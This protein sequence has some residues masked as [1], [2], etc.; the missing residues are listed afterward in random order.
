[1]NIRSVL[2]KFVS[3]TVSAVLIATAV[4]SVGKA[5]TDQQTLRG[6]I[7]TD[8][9]VNTV[10][11]SILG[12]YLKGRASI[13]RQGYINAD[14]DGDGVLDSLDLIL[15]RKII[16]HQKQLQSTT[17]SDVTVSG[18]CM[19]TTICGSCD[20]TV[21]TNVEFYSHE[22][23]LDN[24]AT[25]SAE[26]FRPAT[27]TFTSS[28]TADGFVRAPLSDMQGS[29]SSQGEGRVCILYVDFRDCQYKWSPT[30]SSMNEMAFGE[31]DKS[32][33]NYP[34]ES[35]SA[36]FKRSS[37]QTLNLSGRVYRYT[38][39]HKKAYYERDDHKETLVNEL[40]REM[41]QYVDFNSF[42]ANGDKVIDSIIISVPSQ[43]GDD[44]WWS[45]TANYL[46]EYDGL[47][48]GLAPGHV[49]IGNCEIKSQ[50]DYKSFVASYCHELGHCMGLPDYYLYNNHDSEGLHGSAGYDIMD[51]LYSDFSCASKL[52][53]GWYRS[54]QV[55][56]YNGSQ[57]QTFILRNA[58]TDSGNCVIIPRDELAPNYCSES[59]IIEYTTLDNNNSYIPTQYWWRNFGSGVRVFHMEPSGDNN[60]VNR[61]FLYRSGNNEATNYN[62]GKR[63]IRIVND[64]EFDNLL[65]T[66]SIIDHNQYGFGFYGSYDL[67][68]V[69]PGIE[70]RVGE[71]VDDAYTITISRKAQ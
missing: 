61:N 68:N 23:W 3:F 1:M 32:N 8:G 45:F 47:L 49:V 46:N 30:T 44:D 33:A 57:E 26:V 11:L 67:E 21:T 50:D 71:L 28:L 17:T 39:L 38:T 2:S 19:T 58:Q 53:L 5:D 13:D 66:G 65:R 63:F 40:L 41:D 37:K 42:D 69:D 16:L 70:I 12:L 56:V 51:E 31:E 10:D 22:D 7:N 20:T 4:P 15:L 54:D 25:S 18:C 9:D 64:S 43:A 29:L 59:F 27:S 60:P 24:V 6:D 36:F 34:H 62:L 52:M 48:D 14:M 35:I 55:Q